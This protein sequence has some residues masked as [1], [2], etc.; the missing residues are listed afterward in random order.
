L[1]GDLQYFVDGLK[2]IADILIN[3]DESASKEGEGDGISRTIAGLFNFTVSAETLLSSEELTRYEYA[4][5]VHAI[6]AGCSLAQ[7]LYDIYQNPCFLSKY[8]SDEHLVQSM[9]LRDVLGHAKNCS[10]NKCVKANKVMK[11][12]MGAQIHKGMSQEERRKSQKKQLA[13]EAKDAD[14]VG[15]QE[16]KALAFRNGRERCLKACEGKCDKSPRSLE[17]CRLQ[18]VVQG[19]S[20]GDEG[21]IPQKRKGCPKASTAHMTVLS[22]VR[23]EPAGD[24]T[25]TEASTTIVELVSKGRMAVVEKVLYEE[26]VAREKPVDKKEW[27]VLDEPVNERKP[28][29]PKP[30]YHFIVCASLD[31]F[32]LTCF[33]F[34][35]IILSSH[36]NIFGIS[37][38][39][40]Y[41]FPV[42][43]S[44]IKVWH[45]KVRVVVH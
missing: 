38:S 17:D 27:I 36:S 32:L 21:T 24:E 11:G 8:G 41:S 15:P 26:P 30:R 39:R 44:R 20:S 4:T 22:K 3:H 29:A 33:I 42:T 18:V 1:T 2:S 16:T 19:D 23:V 7:V 31:V 34:T 13:K 5:L 37:S 12:K 28:M 45:L 10:T 9:C 43:A 6:F 40:I 25:V 14:E 35:Y